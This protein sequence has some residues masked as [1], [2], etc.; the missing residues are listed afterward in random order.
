M[1]IEFTQIDLKGTPL[2][3][4]Q[5]IPLLDT[6]PCLAIKGEMGSGKTTFTRV[7]LE[8]LGISNFEGSPTFSIIEPYP[9][10]NGNKL[11]HIDAF[12]VE[13]EQEAFFLGLEDLFQENAYFVV[14]WPEKIS[15]FLP[16]QS[17]LLTIN[18]DFSQNRNY[19]L[20][21]GNES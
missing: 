16:D 2:I 17:M 19:I 6:F 14:E 21:Y 1:Q 18:S 8:S 4:Q 9:L 10:Q 3:A 7:L 20:H 15:N 12:R 13:S 11:Y 5:I